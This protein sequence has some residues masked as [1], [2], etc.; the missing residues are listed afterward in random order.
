MVLSFTF[1]TFSFFPPSFLP[2]LPPFFFCCRLDPAF[3]VTLTAHNAGVR[4][5]ISTHPFLCLMGLKA[6][7]W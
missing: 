2:F 5:Q 4:Q 6:E 7:L 3:I 1:F